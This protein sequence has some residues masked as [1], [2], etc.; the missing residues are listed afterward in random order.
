MP[1]VSEIKYGGGMI[2][3]CYYTNVGVGNSMVSLK[4]TE[5]VILELLFAFVGSWRWGPYADPD[6]ILWGLLK[7]AFPPFSFS[8]RS[9]ETILG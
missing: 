1:Y 9:L 8:M 4:L 2:L 5:H 7:P 3:V 6:N